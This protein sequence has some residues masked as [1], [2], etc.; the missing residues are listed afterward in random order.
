MAHLAYLF[1]FIPYVPAGHA[2]TVALGSYCSTTNNRIDPSSGHF[3]GECG[4]TRFCS[5]PTNGTCQPRLCRRDEFP[6]GFDRGT[7][8]PPLCKNGTFCPDEGSGC[9]PLLSVGETCQYDRDDQ[10]AP[11]T[12][13]KSHVLAGLRNAEEAV[14]LKAKCMHANGTLGHPCVL[15]TAMYSDGEFTNTILRHNCQAPMFYCHSTEGVCV[16]TQKLGLSCTSDQECRSFHCGA[17]GACLDP[18]GTPV[19]VEVWQLVITGLAILAGKMMVFVIVSLVIVHRRLRK[20]RYDE[21]REYY[22]EQTSLRQ[23]LTKLHAAALDNYEKQR[24]RYD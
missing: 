8:L 22:E 18:A 15:D 17:A 7:V 2:T 12:P 6:F 10:C 1:A 21:I 4:D 20:K 14:C 5:G 3:S 16:P 11:P 9:K 19:N 24:S 23:C 13:A